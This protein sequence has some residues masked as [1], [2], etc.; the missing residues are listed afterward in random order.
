MIKPIQRQKLQLMGGE[1]IIS[2]KQYLENAI[3]ILENVKIRQTVVLGV[4]RKP[5]C[6]FP[7][8]DMPGT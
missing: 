8:I 1:I 6:V 4:F 3:G 5:I 2:D 7:I